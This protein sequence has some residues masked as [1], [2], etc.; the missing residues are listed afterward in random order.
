[1]NSDIITTHR[2]GPKFQNDESNCKDFCN[3]DD[4]DDNDNDDDDDDGDDDDDDD[5]DDG[6]F[7]ERKGC[8]ESIIITKNT[9][10]DDDDLTRHLFRVFVIKW[11]KVRCVVWPYLTLTVKWRICEITPAT[12]K[13]MLTKAYRKFHRTVKS[14]LCQRCAIRAR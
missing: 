13:T 6:N 4:D 1:M 9:H 7:D 2:Y 3:D 12:L 10:D 5:D 14:C 8:W 11:P